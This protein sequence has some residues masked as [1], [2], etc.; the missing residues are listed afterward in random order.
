MTGKELKEFAESLRNGE[1]I[2]ETLFYQLANLVKTKIEGMRNWKVLES[3]DTSKTASS[4]DT[5]LTTK[6]LPTDFVSMTELFTARTDGSGESYYH[7]IPFKKRHSY[8]S[9]SNKYYIDYKNKKFALCG[10]I[11]DTRTIHQIYKCKTGD[12]DESTGWEFPGD[13]HPIIGFIVVAIIRSGVDY[14]TYNIAMAIN[15]ND[16]AKEILDMMITWDA[17]LAERE[18]DDTY[19]QNTSCDSDGL[20]TAE[21]GDSNLGN[22]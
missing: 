12:I 3:E 7:P 17:E 4:G 9:V 1:T 8:Q 2:E 15:N 22:Y 18:M 21:S 6:D 20:P 13:F 16:E 5:F 11:S 10:T 14:D 19:D